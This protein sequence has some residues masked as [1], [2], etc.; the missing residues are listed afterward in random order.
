[1]KYLIILIAMLI[2]GCSSVT[3]VDYEKSSLQKF[4]LKAVY[5]NSLYD[6][7]V[8]NEHTW[9]SGYENVDFTKPIIVN[10][11][12]L[13]A[14]R[15]K[16]YAGDGFYM[17]AIGKDKL[18]MW[19]REDTVASAI[20]PLGDLNVSVITTFI[21]SKDYTPMESLWW[22]IEA[23]TNSGGMYIEVIAFIEAYIKE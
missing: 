10:R 4:T 9:T 18:G 17:F 22:K 3:S 15:P 19:T 2:V 5:E 8:G 20:S 6:V 16:L 7:F 21:Y 12:V 13:S 11:L 1:M 14:K 23:P